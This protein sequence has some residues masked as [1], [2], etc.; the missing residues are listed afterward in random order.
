MR[1][2]G[3]GGSESDREAKDGRAWCGCAWHVGRRMAGVRFAGEGGGRGGRQRGAFVLAAA[4]QGASGRRRGDGR[5][6]RGR[7]RALGDAGATLAGLRRAV[8]LPLSSPALSRSYCG[9]A[10]GCVQPPCFPVPD[11]RTQLCSPLPDLGFLC[12]CGCLF[13]WFFLTSAAPSMMVRPPRLQGNVGRC[14]R[15]CRR[16]RSRR[17]RHSNPSPLFTS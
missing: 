12:L 14:R 11:V 7:R 6:P 15:C 17:L 16:C 5:P 13:P 10:D 1:W 2:G 8:G 3:G 4:T 9:A